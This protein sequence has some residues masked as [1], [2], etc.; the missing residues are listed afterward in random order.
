MV[1]AITRFVKA[2]MKDWKESNLNMHK[3]AVAILA[4]CCT[5]CAD[6]P[7]KAFYV[8]APFLTDKI[9]DVKLAA[10]IKDVI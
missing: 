5:H 10:A 9:G 7:K 8:Y 2:K 6:V 3:E 4:A 1:E